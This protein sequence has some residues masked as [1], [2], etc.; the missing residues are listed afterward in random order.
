MAVA[1]AAGRNC[2]NRVRDPAKN[3]HFG[4]KFPL[5]GSLKIKIILFTC[6]NIYSKWIAFILNNLTQQGRKMIKF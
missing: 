1:T 6:F 3:D 4:T 5:Q 2:K